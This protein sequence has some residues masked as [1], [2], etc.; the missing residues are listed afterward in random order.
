M[1]PMVTNQDLFFCYDR[2]LSLYIFKV[3]K[4]RYLTKAKSSTSGR[5]F[6]LYARCPEIQEAIQH[7]FP[8]KEETK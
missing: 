2:N 5:T 8:S 1:R 4:I 3:K 6:A 7:F